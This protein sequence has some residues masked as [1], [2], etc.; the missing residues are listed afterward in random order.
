M[1]TTEVQRATPGSGSSV[2]FS[3]PVTAGNTVYLGLVGFAFA[4]DTLTSSSPTL[5]GSPVTGAVKLADKL[6]EFGGSPGVVYVA[7]WMLP[8]VAGGETTAA[9]T[10]G[11]GGT[12]LNLFAL[13]AAGMG[14]LPTLDQSASAEHPDAA[15]PTAGPTGDTTAASEL[16]IGI[17]ALLGV[18][19]SAPPSPF[20]TNYQAGASNFCGWSSTVAATAGETFT[21][22]QSSGAGE[23]SWAALVVTVA[24]TASGDDT[25]SAALTLQPIASA[26][27]ASQHQHAAIAASL[28]PL[29]SAAAASQHQHAAVSA[30]L[31]PIT[32]AADVAQR[33]HAAAAASLPPVGTAAAGSQRATASAALSLPPIAMSAT[34]SPRAIA[35]AA[36]TL[37][38]VASAATVA[39]RVAATV[40]GTLAPLATSATILTPYRASA[41]ITLAAIGAVIRAQ[42]TGQPEALDWPD[43]EA[44]LRDV[45][46]D[47]APV[48]TRTTPGLAANLPQIRARRIGGSDDWTTDTA[49]CDVTVFAATIAQAKQI[50]GQARQRLIITPSATD[51]GVIDRVKTEVAPAELGTDDPAQVRAVNATYRLTARRRQP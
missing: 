35:S 43:F 32:S 24:P 45:L 36:V 29:A 5:G 11:G 13:E 8:N 26:A 31:Q 6:S 44:M 25:A 7:I 37:P 47:L 17:A 12:A 51:D 18:A 33:Q 4:N 23:N 20:D 46:G 39:A 27:A 41:A 1:S 9:I 48:V 14:A 50:A 21:Y 16:V 2:T 42:T 22:S 28:Q 10:L 49:R 3:S 30:S 19:M 15:S 34:S 38:P 40:T